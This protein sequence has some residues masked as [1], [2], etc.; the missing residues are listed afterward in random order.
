MLPYHPLI[1]VVGLRGFVQELTV[2]HFLTEVLQSVEWLVEL[3]G[4]GDF[5]QVF[6]NV[7]PQDIP[8]VNV[9]SV[10]ARSRQAG[11]T[12]IAEGASC[13]LPIQ[14]WE[15]KKSRESDA[16]PFWLC[17]I[18]AEERTLS[19]DSDC[20]TS[21][22]INTQDDFYINLRASAQSVRVGF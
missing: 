15:R 16:P 10:R 9:T 2:L 11:S 6:A 4:H 18:R 5:G 17:N 13:E 19:W 1:G 20:N 3:H 8:Q 7:V 12:A 22:H 14:D 21:N